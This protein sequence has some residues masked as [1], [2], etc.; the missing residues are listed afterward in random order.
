MNIF[1]RICDTKK[2]PAILSALLVLSGNASAS[3]TAGKTQVLWL[4]QSAA[5]AC[6]HV[7]DLKG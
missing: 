6:L 2:I 3:N 7:G 5:A 1:L 4:G